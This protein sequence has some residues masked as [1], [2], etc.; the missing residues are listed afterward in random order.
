VDTANLPEALQSLIGNR[1]VYEFS[2]TGGGNTISQFG[3]NVTVAVPYRLSAGEDPNAVIISFINAGGKLEIVTNGRYDA[4]TGTVVFNTDHF[5]KYAIGYNKIDFTDVADS[6]WYV[7]AVTFL[8]ARGITGGTMET[9]FSPDGT[10]TRGQ[11]I[12]LL[13]R[14]YD[15]AADENTAN[16]FSDAGNTYYT[17]YLAAARRLDITSGVGDNKFAPE[18][19]ITR[20]EMFTLLYNALKAL[21]K[22]PAG[23]SG[24]TLANFTDSDSVADWATEALTALAKSGIVAGS[25]GKLDP[26]VGSTRAQMAQVLYNLLGK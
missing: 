1:P 26:T 8:A 17:G 22:L 20:Q 15:M 9:T 25:G 12:T 7:D 5:S 16:N 4:A 19:A 23:D 24:K 18:Q 21:D 14:A 13:M 6:A 2:V 11:F 3:G 10:L